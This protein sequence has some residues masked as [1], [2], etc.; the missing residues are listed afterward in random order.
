[1]KNT[2]KVHTSLLVHLNSYKN[3]RGMEV[4]REGVPFNPL[5]NQGYLWVGHAQDTE[6]A[7]S[8]EYWD[9]RWWWDY[10]QRIFVHPY[11]PGARKQAV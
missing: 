3:N 8:S 10:A 6:A 4:L 11:T 1:M 9:G 7:H 2:T 5:H